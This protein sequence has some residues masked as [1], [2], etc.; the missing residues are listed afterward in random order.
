MVGN[1]RRWSSGRGGRAAGGLV[2]SLAVLLGLAEAGGAAPA[3]PDDVVQLKAERMLRFEADAQ[4]LIAEGNVRLAYRQTILEADVLQVDLKSDLVRAEGH[5]RYQK[6]DDR[7]E[8]GSA[9][10]D[11]KQEEGTF[12]G[13]ATTYQVEDLKGEVIVQGS[14]MESSKDT[15]R[16]VRSSL[17]T[18]DLAQ[19]HYHLEAKE[20]TIYLDDRLEARQVSGFE[21]K[22]KL[23]TLPYLIIP[24]RKE[25]QF[26]LP[27]LGYSQSDGWFIKTTYNYY[28][29]AASYGA[30][31][32]DWYQKKGMGL[33]LKHDYLQGAKPWDGSG[34]WYLYLK[35]NR[36]HHDEEV[37]LGVDHRQQLGPAWKSAWRG[38]Y[39]ERYLSDTQKQ[40]AAG[41]TVQVTQQSTA[42]LTD[43][44]AS[45][46]LTVSQTLPAGEGESGVL[47][48]TDLK[49]ARV[50]FNTAQRLPGEWDWRFGASATRFQQAGRTPYDNLGYQT[51]VAKA[52]PDFTLRLSA[53]Q[54]FTPPP[55]AEGE[56]PPPWSRYSRL[57][58][59]ALESRALTYRGKPLPLNFSASLSRYEEISVYHPDGYALTMGALTGRLTGLSYPLGPRVTTSFTGSGSTTYYQNGDYTLGAA[60]GLGLTYRPSTPVAATLRYNWQDRLGVNPFVSTGISP[61]ETIGGNLSYT[62]GGLNADVGTSYDLLTGYFQELV[63]RATLSRPRFSAT[64]LVSYDPNTGNWRRA[65]GVYSYEVDEAHLLKLGAAADLGSSRLERFDTQVVW[66]LSARWRAELTLSYDGFLNRFT[67]FEAT[68]ARDLHCQEVRLRYDDVR[69]EV[70]FE[71]RINALPFQLFRFGASEERLMFDSQSLGDLLSPG[72][73]IMGVPR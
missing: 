30:Y 62:A 59:V 23:F 9:V 41:A 54:Q 12:Y 55:V 29:N 24:L 6:G 28:R 66:P 43:L 42:G 47:S 45:Y 70:W 34:W 20:I 32:L 26:E 63:G 67:R 15:L 36:E 1:S 56:T 35:G 61:A 25:N 39:E 49:D 64:G 52:F 18:C 69:R 44:S 4:L 8:A 19:P 21:G 57:P 11:L 58:E 31:F 14:F 5:V 40:E 65:A 68:L 16:L 22:V 53:Q 27:R 3:S 60:T 72:Q 51:Q 2:L 33:G 38:N 7:L 71:W 73:T 37:Y 48:Q 46:R 13:V 50:S 10:Y 17:T